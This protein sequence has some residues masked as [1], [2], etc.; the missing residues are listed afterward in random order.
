MK[1]K[2]S[3]QPKQTKEVESLKPSPV[4]SQNTTNKEKSSKSTN[5]QKRHVSDKNLDSI[6]K[7]QDS[8]E[9]NQKNDQK[10]VLQEN[11]IADEN[12]FYLL[13]LWLSI[14]GIPAGFNNYLFG[15]YYGTICNENNFNW[16]TDTVEFAKNLAI[17]NS[18]NYFGASFGSF[19]SNYQLRFNLR[20][21]L[22]LMC[23]LT[24][25]C[26][27]C[28]CITHK[29]LFFASRL[30]IGYTSASQRNTSTIFINQLNVSATRNIVLSVKR[31]TNKLAQPIVFFLAIFDDGGK[32][33]WRF[34]I[35]LQIVPCLFYIILAQTKFKDFDAPVRLQKLGK[36]KQLEKMYLTHI[37]PEY[38]V[39]M[40][41]NI[42]S[43]QKKEEDSQ[44]EV[45]DKSFAFLRQIYNIYFY[46]FIYATILS[47]M[48]SSVYLIDFWTIY[49]VILLK[50]KGDFNSK[51]TAKAYAFAMKMWQI[52]S[53]LI[54][55]KFK[56]SKYRKSVFVLGVF[57][58]ALNWFT[59]GMFFYNNSDAYTIPFG[60]ILCSIEGSM[61]L[62][63]YT[64][65]IETCG[66]NLYSFA[67]CAYQMM[68]SMVSGTTP[69]FITDVENYGNICM[70]STVKLV[71]IGI[72][73]LWFLIET[74]GLER[75]YIYEIIRGKTTRAQALID[76]RNDINKI[77]EDIKSK[78]ES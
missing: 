45:G 33:F 30:I 63:F 73:S 58:Y 32:F 52:I 35:C 14:C 39:F 37:K 57:L 22:L 72:F 50:N 17:L 64:I 69:F 56:F 36:V 27:L 67:V 70:F 13:V 20:K 62:H 1:A 28:Q 66:E 41:D 18:F 75:K 42:Q 15:P 29:Y 8:K 12:F 55:L 21:V 76:T 9:K 5:N 6:S 53:G 25:I 11:P 77:K 10:E 24:I 65:V 54:G 4:S 2:P 61:F 74:Q 7:I 31:L 47:F 19:T 46:E 48:M 59:L 38:S 16:R 60:F 49:F 23:V 44:K 26:A 3:D 71:I 43:L 51:A 40:I 78:K 34:T 68:N